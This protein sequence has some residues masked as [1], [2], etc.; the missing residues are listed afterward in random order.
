MA[1]AL[2]HPAL[3]T[4]LPVQLLV[5]PVVGGAALLPDLD[6][7]Q[8]KVSQSLGPLTRWLSH[9]VNGLSLIVYHSTRGPGDSPAL[10]DGHRLLTH[11][12]I[13]CLSTGLIHLLI[14]RV[15]HLLIPALELPG[16][17]SVV[18]GLVSLSL[19][20]SLN[21]W[22]V[23]SVR[24]P[25]KT[26]VRAAGDAVLPEPLEEA[27]AAG[28]RHL[29]PMYLL[30]TTAGGWYVLSHYPGWWWLWP[31]C[32]AVGCLTHV[33]GD[34]LTNSGVP[35]WWIPGW[36]DSAGRSWG[37]SRA[38]IT[39]RTGEAEEVEFVRRVLWLILGVS[40]LWALGWLSALIQ[41][42]THL[43]QWVAQEVT[44]A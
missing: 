14:D 21:M 4:P 36:T 20:M 27:A 12:L 41:G 29:L 40:S 39:F 10:S 8:A 33:A 43:I 24:R 2:D 18:P 7:P 38:W 22:W 31:T 5:I 3:H 28:V 17:L 6:H 25:L 32:I 11:T 34:W 23:K 26:L 35:L 44:H 1:G 19:V 13:G 37:R 42:V 9:R 16:W 30:V 15:S